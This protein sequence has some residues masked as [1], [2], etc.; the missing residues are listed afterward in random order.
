ML[1][2]I[3]ILTRVQLANF[4]NLNV[5]RYTKD[6]KKKY[7]MMAL[8]PIW[9]LLILMV[10]FYV[11]ALSYGYILIGMEDVLPM[12]LVMIAGLITLVFGIFK[13]GI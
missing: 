5:F 12:Y 10:F 7:T 11:G 8:T 13:A 9:A 3:S 1:K 4:W 2:Q 6:K